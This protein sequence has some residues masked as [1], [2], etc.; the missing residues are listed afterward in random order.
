MP[1]KIKLAIR[2]GFKATENKRFAEA[3]EVRFINS[4]D[5]KILFRYAPKCE[6][7]AIFI[8]IF[9]LLTDYDDAVKALRTIHNNIEGRGYNMQGYRTANK[10]EETQEATK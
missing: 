3:L 9:K 2:E 10:E 6:D 8:E 4:V 5:G 7:E 1:I